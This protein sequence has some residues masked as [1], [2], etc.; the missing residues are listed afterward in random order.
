[1]HFQ[2]YLHT[3]TVL[4]HLHTCTVLAHNNLIYGPG[5]SSY[6]GS[7]MRSLHSI[8]NQL[9]NDL[10]H[11]WWRPW[12]CSLDGDLIIHQWMALNLLR[13]DPWC[14]RPCS[15]APR[16]GQHY[17]SITH[18]NGAQALLFHLSLLL[19]STVDDTCEQKCIVEGISSYWYGRICNKSIMFFFCEL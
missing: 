10:L 5:L 9:R 15:K 13:N 1:M 2:L 17:L 12:R 19:V 4:V 14:W 11:C 7:K 3:C 8:S 6:T 18:R 16:G